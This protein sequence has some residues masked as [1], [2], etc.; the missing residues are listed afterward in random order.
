VLPR[1]VER[2]T[3]AERRWLRYAVRSRCSCDVST[4]ATCARSPT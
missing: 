3:R 1:N 2:S 4:S